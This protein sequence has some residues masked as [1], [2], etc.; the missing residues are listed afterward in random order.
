M[1]ASDQD[2]NISLW[3]LKQDKENFLTNKPIYK[4]IRKAHNPDEIVKG[5]GSFL[6]M[7]IVFSSDSKYLFSG[8]RDGTIQI[9]NIE[10]IKQSD[11][12]SIDSSDHDKYLFK[13]FNQSEEAFVSVAFNDTKNLLAF[14]SWS[15]KLWL[16]NLDESQKPKVLDKKDE[17]ERIW[18]LAF[19]PDG[20]LL[21]TGGVDEIVYLWNIENP[22]QP[23]LLHKLKGHTDE[24]FCVAFSPDGKW[25]ASA[26]RDCQILLWNRKPTGNKIIDRFLW[27]FY[28]PKPLTDH[29][30]GIRSIAF[31]WDS[32]RL[33]S[34]SEDQSIHLWNLDKLDDKLEV[35]H[36]HFHGV[37]SVAFNSK[38]S[39]SLR[40]VSCSWDRTIRLWNLQSEPRIFEHPRKNQKNQRDIDAIAV[41]FVS[42]QKFAIG[43]ADATVV[44]RNIEQSPDSPPER[45]YHIKDRMSFREKI[46]Y[47]RKFSWAK[48]PDKSVSILTFFCEN[49]HLKKIALSSS[50]SSAIWLWNFSEKRIIPIKAKGKVNS[51]AFSPDGKMLVSGEKV[52]KNNQKAKTVWIEAWNLTKKGPL[53]I[54]TKSYEM[55]DYTFKRF[56]SVAYSPK[57]DNNKRYLAVSDNSGEIKLFNGDTSDEKENKELENICSATHEKGFG[58]DASVVLAFSSDGKKLASA[59]DVSSI[60]LWNRQNIQN[61]KLIEYQDFPPHKDEGDEALPHRNFWITSVAL[62]PKNK[63]LASGRYDGSIQLWDL[64]DPNHKPIVLNGHREK[65]NAIAFSPDGK[66]L[67]SASS[68]NTVRLWTINT[69]DLA[70]QLKTKLYR[71][72]TDEEQEKYLGESTSRT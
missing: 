33:A 34:A 60:R 42:K 27:H 38:N 30:Q 52:E 54:Q 51:L 21:A 19:H 24:I 4:F 72:L 70:D 20:N 45:I 69:K 66:Y 48:D 59:S 65:I 32:K 8:A 40:L 47:D 37:S 12:E 2:G 71:G 28:P 14:G 10:K 36:G 18:S 6:D 26:S 56:V 11:K 9:W 63:W 29:Q 41:Q 16:W 31:D 17:N 39:N 35:L 67:V 50:Y 64:K 57:I 3:Y 1:T 62:D 44:I 15:G 68:D 25:L 58:G 46:N 23:K 43:Y 61:G 5:Q 55:E 49:D 13:D 7:S 22:K 53:P